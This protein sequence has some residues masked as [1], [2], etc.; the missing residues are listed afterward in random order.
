MF[1]TGHLPREGVEEIHRYLRPGGYFV[2]AMRAQYYQPEEECG[3]HGVFQ[4]LQ[5][6][7]KFVIHKQYAFKR[8]LSDDENVSGNPHFKQLDSLLFV[9]QKL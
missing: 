2:T 5:D 4:K 3:Y 6:E 9:F 7:N 1:L 8:G